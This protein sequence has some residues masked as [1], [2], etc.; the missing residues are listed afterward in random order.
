MLPPFINATK[1]RNETQT[2]RKQPERRTVMQ[3][4]A[5]TVSACWMNA[6]AAELATPGTSTSVILKGIATPSELEWAELVEPHYIPGNLVNKLA[7][8]ARPIGRLKLPR[9]QADGNHTADKS[10]DFEENLKLRQRIWRT[11]CLLPA[12]TFAYS[13][14]LS[15]ENCWQIQRYFGRCVKVIASFLIDRHTW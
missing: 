14:L 6:R 11:V 9:K 13:L 8:V 2:S 7:N 5:A 10:R 4:V 12:P 15:M 1:P 3:L